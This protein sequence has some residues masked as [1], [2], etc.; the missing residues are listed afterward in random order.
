MATMAH[1]PLEDEQ[2]ALRET[3]S[4]EL[5][6]HWMNE[7]LAPEVLAHQEDL[8]ERALSR[9]QQ[10]SLALDVLANNPEGLSSSD[11][12]RFMLIE[13]EIEHARYICKAYARCRMYKL[14]KFFDHCLMDPE[15]RSR[16]SKVDLEYCAREQT[17]VHNLLYD[18][19]LDQLPIKYRKLDEDHMIIRPDLDQGVFIIVRS[20]C[21]PAVLPH[22]EPL[23]LEKGSK[24]FICYRSIKPFLESGHVKLV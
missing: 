1:E 14:D 15:T 7:R 5:I 12:F 8:M 22:T 20:S 10:Q 19:V 13:T 4:E 24:H 2:D 11:H 16:L 23:M 3:F 9:I 17:L 21:G 6:R 18:S